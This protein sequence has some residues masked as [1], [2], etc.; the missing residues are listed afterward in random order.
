MIHTFKIITGEETVGLYSGG[1]SLNEQQ[2]RR[3]VKM[4]IILETESNVLAELY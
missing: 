3:P 2:R 1:G 4:Q